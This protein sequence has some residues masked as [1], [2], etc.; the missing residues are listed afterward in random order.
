MKFYRS[1]ELSDK[2]E[3][4]VEE[5]K[6]QG[7]NMAKNIAHTNSLVV[8]LDEETNSKNRHIEGSL[9]FV[10]DSSNQIR[11]DIQVLILL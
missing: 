1:V 11:A 3:K 7:R 8:R 6:T 4:L 2:V 10:T 9:A 5:I